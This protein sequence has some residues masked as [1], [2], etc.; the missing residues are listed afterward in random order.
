MT[1]ALQADIIG[2]IALTFPAEWIALDVVRNPGQ[3]R[4]APYFGV[5]CPT[6]INEVSISSPTEGLIDWAFCSGAISK[7]VSH[8][9]HVNG[10]HL[11]LELASTDD[12]TISCGPA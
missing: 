1:L 2:L 5:R 7:M 8:F 11:Q 4:I 9:K 6:S 12:S 10:M 3:W